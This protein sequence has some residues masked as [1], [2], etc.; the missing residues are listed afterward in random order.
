M[1]RLW[2]IY[3]VVFFFYNQGYRFQNLPNSLFQSVPSSH[4]L[5]FAT[6]SL[7]G[8]FAH[9]P[10]IKLCA[11]RA[12]FVSARYNDCIQQLEAIGFYTTEQTQLLL[13]NAYKMA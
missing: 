11:A 9:D 8:A 2:A 13:T 3:L 5:S 4:A 7:I 6:N 10:E 12:F 1:A